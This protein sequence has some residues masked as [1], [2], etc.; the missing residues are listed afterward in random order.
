MASESKEN[1]KGCLFFFLILG[2]FGGILGA[3]FSGDEK[4]KTKKDIDKMSIGRKLETVD[5][6]GYVTED[7]SR[8]LR[9]NS[10][11]KD[12]SNRFNE[13]VDSIAEDTQ[14][15]QGVLH[16][17]GIDVSCLEILKVM[18]TADRKLYKNYQEACFLYY[19]VADQTQ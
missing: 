5:T 3:I 2:V 18:R 15:L 17:K 11:L 7:D 4:D 6:K 16:N 14:K 12:V 10:L 9:A 8:V 1:M 13:P 19:L